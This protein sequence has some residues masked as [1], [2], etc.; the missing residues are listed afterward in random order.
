M[1]TRYVNTASTPGGDGTTNA[2]VGANRAYASLSEWEGARNAV[3]SEVEEVICEGSA[4]DTAALTIVGW[5]TSAANYISIRT[6]TAGRH[7]G[8]WNTSKYRLYVE[9][10]TPI[11]Q[12]EDYVRIEGL[13][14]GCHTPPG[15]SRHAAMTMTTALASGA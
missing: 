13:Q 5:T 3:L 11:N 14:I 15:V 8:K 4:A 1:A 10:S 12:Q 2:T 7:D 9:N 6:D